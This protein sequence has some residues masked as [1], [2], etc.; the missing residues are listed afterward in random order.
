MRRQITCLLLFLCSLSVFAVSTPRSAKSVTLKLA[1]VINQGGPHLKYGIKWWISDVKPDIQGSY[2][3]L[4]TSTESEPIF[5]VTPGEYRVTIAYANAKTNRQITISNKTKQTRVIAIGPGRLRLTATLTKDGAPLKRNLRWTVRPIDSNLDRMKKLIEKT[6]TNP[7]FQLP[8]GRYRIRAHIGDVFKYKDV[9]V[10]AGKMMQKTFVLNAG[11]LVL[12]AKFEG[13]GREILKHLRWKLYR[14]D[15]S[16]PVLLSKDPKLTL[17]LPVGEYRV[18]V[19]YGNTFKEVP[20]TI[21][22]GI[23]IQKS[24]VLDAGELILR[25]TETAEGPLIYHPIRWWIQSA[26]KQ[27]NEKPV[28]RH[29]NEATFLLKAGD[30]LLKAAYGHSKSSLKVHLNSGERLKKTIDFKVGKIRMSAV[31][32]DNSRLLDEVSWRVYSQDHLLVEK[33]GSE[34]LFILSEGQY[35]IKARWHNLTAVS[36]ITIRSGQ[37]ISQT[38]VLEP[39]S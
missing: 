31:S 11:D 15:K 7:V 19:E 27:A 14:A 8:P 6:S 25:G 10:T 17:V 34:P 23:S 28:F 4:G 2:K 13:T 18:K 5:R 32:E 16:D 30:Y 37:R 39:R 29:T 21:T 38:I 24:L 12:D 20:I 26:Y 22:A 36:L 9:D 35:R 1:A 33:R 3:I